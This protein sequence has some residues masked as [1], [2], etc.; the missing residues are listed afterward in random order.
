MR[1]EVEPIYELGQLEPVAHIRTPVPDDTM[2]FQ[3]WG[4][5]DPD[6]SLVVVALEEYEDFANRSPR[7]VLTLLAEMS[8]DSYALPRW[9]EAVSV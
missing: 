2:T 1:W 3:V 9:W 4:A 7:D 8:K 6:T 5:D